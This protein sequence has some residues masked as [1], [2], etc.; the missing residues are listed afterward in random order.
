MKLNVRFRLVQAQESIVN[1]AKTIGPGG[2]SPAFIQFAQTKIR[3]FL[4][5]NE[6][7]RQVI[8][9]FVDHNAY[10]GTFKKSICL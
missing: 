4:G 8:V 7:C 5:V 2:T 6:L 3:S 1:Q 10:T 9:A